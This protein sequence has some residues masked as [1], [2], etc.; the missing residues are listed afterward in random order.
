MNTN[1]SVHNEQI[2]DYNYDIKDIITHNIINCYKEYTV[3]EEIDFVYLDKLDK[4]I[5]KYITDKKLFKR[6]NLDEILNS[7][8]SIERVFEIYETFEEQTALQVTIARWI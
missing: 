3:K 6:I 1:L 8:F 7:N 5:Y 2:M 4:V